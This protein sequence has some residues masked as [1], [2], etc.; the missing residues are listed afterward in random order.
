M[1]YVILGIAV[2][3]IL[4]GIF[5]CTKDDD[6]GLGFCVFGEL[7]FIGTFIAIIA[8]LGCYNSTKSTAKEQIA[9]IEEQNTIILEQLEPLVN[10]YM[11]YEKDTYKEFKLSGEKLLLISQAYPELKSDTFVQTQIDTVLKNQNRIMAIK[12]S[13]ARLNAYKLWICMGAD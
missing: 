3:I 5:I 13:I 1:L 7:S 9:V 11:E 2:L 8:C 10:K 12:L 6:I 4:L